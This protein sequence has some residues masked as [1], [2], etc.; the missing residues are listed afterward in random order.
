ML[1]LPNPPDGTSITVGFDG[2]DSDDHTALRAET[3]EGFQFTP[4]YGPDRRPTIWDPAEWDGQIPRDEV[5]AAMDEVYSRFV[6]LRGYFD[7]P[8]WRSEIGDWSLLYGAEHVTEWAT[9]R[10]TQMHEALKRF[11]TDLSTNRTTHDGC[12]VTEIAVA[13]ARKKARPGQRY[14]LSKPTQTQ[15]IDPAMA[16]VLAHEAASDARADNWPE[17]RPV[18]SRMIVF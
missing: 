6:V 17:P 11:V 13:N 1:W 5:H 18:S 2:S 3:R 15:K 7:P 14:I 9:Y 10:T 16:S 12:P 8:D 4:R